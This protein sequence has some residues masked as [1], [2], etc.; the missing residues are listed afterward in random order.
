MVQ[1]IE[2]KLPI[3]GVTMNDI[4]TNLESVEETPFNESP[5]SLF[6]DTYFV[7]L[8]YLAV[9]LSLNEAIVLQLLHSIL[10][11]GPQPMDGY[12]WVHKTYEQFRKQHFPFWSLRTIAR[13][14][15]KLETKGLI[16]ASIPKLQPFDMTKSYRIDY[17]RLEELLRMNKQ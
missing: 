14:F 13:T 11:D 9:I 17:E 15:R 2:K 8:P 12:N 5:K 6:T 16:I 3:G 7:C 1:T 10:E 4:R